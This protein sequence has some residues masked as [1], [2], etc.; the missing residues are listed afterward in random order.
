M[1]PDLKSKIEELATAYRDEAFKN[2]PN[3]YSVFPG[4]NEPDTDFLV[5][6]E[7]MFKL[8]EERRLGQELRCGECG[9]VGML[10]GQF[11][12]IDRIQALEAR[13]SGFCIRAGYL[14]SDLSVTNKASVVAAGQCDLTWNK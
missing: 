14:G 7:A 8:M 4:C 3:G 2:N 10:A 11:N 6:A 5:G 12:Y 9:N 13:D 1:T